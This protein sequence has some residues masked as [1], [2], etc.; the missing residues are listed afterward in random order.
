MTVLTFPSGFLWG[1]ATA[2]HQVEGGTSESDW[3]EWET[4]PSTPCAEPSGLACDHL[5][6]YPED[7]AIPSA[8]GLGAYR[9]PVEWARIEP[10]EGAFSSEALDHSVRMTDAVVG[11]G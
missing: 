1:A 4:E 5:H 6:R 9:Y 8:V 7:L 3:W 10:A 2:A 11:A